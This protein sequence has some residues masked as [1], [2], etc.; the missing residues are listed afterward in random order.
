MMYYEIERDTNVNL[1][2]C[3][4]YPYKILML[5]LLSLRVM[6]NKTRFFVV[7]FMF[8]HNDK[9]YIFS[10]RMLC[11]HKTQYDM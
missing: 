4:T 10:N 5:V 6:F 2:D 9:F 1:L 3:H 8:V 7:N 11:W